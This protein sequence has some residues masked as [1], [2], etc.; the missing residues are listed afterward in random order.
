MTT[1]LIE[2]S[3]NSQ[4]VAEVKSKVD[5]IDVESRQYKCNTEKE[6]K[7]RS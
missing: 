5:K 6:K 7:C 2:A 1:R 3:N 4:T